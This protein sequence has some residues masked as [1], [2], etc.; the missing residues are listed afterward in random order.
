MVGLSPSTW[1]HSFFIIIRLIAVLAAVLSFSRWVTGEAIAPIDVSLAR[2]KPTCAE[3]YRRV[4]GVEPVFGADF[5]G[6]L[7]SHEI[8][9]LSLLDADEELCEIHEKS[10]EK[11]A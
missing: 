3:E 4:F 9:A 1:F 8:L 7:I 11:S 5:D 6:V 10:C 2:K